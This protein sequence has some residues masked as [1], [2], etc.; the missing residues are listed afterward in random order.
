MT[1]RNHE[2]QIFLSHLLTI[3]GFFFLLTSKYLIL[4]WKNMKKTSRKSWIRWDTTWSRNFNFTMMSR[5]EVRRH[6]AVR[7]LSFP[8]AGMGMWDRSKNNGNLDLVCK[9]KNS[10]T[11]RYACIFRVT[12]SICN[13]VN[14][15]KFRILISFSSQIKSRYQGWNSQNASWNSKQGR[16]WSNCFFC[17][18]L[19]FR[20]A[21]SIQNASGLRQWG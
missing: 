10:Y 17:L 13:T 11:T 5:I 20:Q 7:F 2:G 4:Y 6:A 9:K 3:N 14:V 21:T 1:Y 15:L 19:P 16:P 8:L 18:S 12:L